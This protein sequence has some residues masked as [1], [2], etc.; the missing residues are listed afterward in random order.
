MR[1][2]Y[3]RNLEVQQY[4][5]HPFVTAAGSDGEMYSVLPLVWTLEQVDVYYNKFAPHKILSDEVPKGREG[6][7]TF[8]LSSGALW[9][10]IVK[11][12]DGQAVG[13][14]YI[15]DLIRSRIENRYLSAQFHTAFWDSKMGSRI[16]LFK[17]FVRAIFAQFKLHRLEAEIPLFAAG[18]IRLAKKSGFVPE[19]VRRSAKRYNGVWWS[20]MRLA[21]TEGDL[22]GNS[23]VGEPA[24]C[25]RC[26]Q[27][28]PK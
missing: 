1:L 16:P 12:L 25:E 27:I 5:N 14:A 9:F 4:T 23:P 26:G 2:R 18:A 13:V 24:L 8:V 17:A 19:G 11:E 7:E 3:M 6:F 28:L 22:Y 21:I 15:T 20:L 10:E